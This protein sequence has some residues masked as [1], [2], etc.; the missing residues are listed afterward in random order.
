MNEPWQDLVATM[1]VFSS[2]S[3]YAALVTSPVYPK[4]KTVKKK[5]KNSMVDF[6]GG[7]CLG[8]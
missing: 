2:V 6:C 5:K 7:F 3:L 4:M 1:S 8:C